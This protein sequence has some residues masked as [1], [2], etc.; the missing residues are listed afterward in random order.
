MRVTNHATWRII[1][2]LLLGGSL[3]ACSG[4]P[5]FPSD[6]RLAACFANQPGV[7][8]IETF[9]VAHVSDLFPRMK[10]W[11]R[12]RIGAGTDERPA[13]VVRLRGKL[14]IEQPAVGPLGGHSFEADDPTCLIVLAPDGTF[15]EGE[16]P[17]FLGPISGG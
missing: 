1:V 3:A 9:Q 17:L 13:F 6:W 11:D 5:G 10:S 4:V 12:D 8:I 15:P 16:T 7:A 2:G 14:K